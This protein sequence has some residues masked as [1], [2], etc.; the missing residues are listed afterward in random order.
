MFME[1]IPLTWKT[2]VWQRHETNLKFTEAR[3]IRL[4]FSVRLFKFSSDLR[5]AKP[6]WA[7]SKKKKRQKKR[8]RSDYTSFCLPACQSLIFRCS[9]GCF[10]KS[11]PCNSFGTAREKKL[12][13]GSGWGVK[14]LRQRRWGWMSYCVPGGDS[15]WQKLRQ[16]GRAAPRLKGGQLADGYR[17]NHKK[18]DRRINRREIWQQPRLWRGEL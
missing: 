11:I 15:Q 18:E 2:W 3:Q 14:R 1:I 10:D 8:H 12:F 6:G 5:D 7:F 16:Q 13:G 9:A 4:D 17:E